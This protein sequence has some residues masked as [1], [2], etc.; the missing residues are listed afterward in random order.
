MFS[1]HTLGIIT[2]LPQ[3]ARTLTSGRLSCKQIMRLKDRIYLFIGGMG[4]ENS[5]QAATTL[6]KHGAT[7]LISW[8]TAGALNPI[9]QAGDLIIPTQ[10]KTNKPNTLFTVDI[11]HQAQLIT[12]LP[13]SL[14]ISQQAVL[15]SNSMVA[16]V[17]D[18]Q[19]LYQQHQAAAIDMESYAIATAAHNANLAFL[20]IRAI[21][22]PA[23]MCL[24]H[25]ATRAYDLSGKLRPFSLINQ[26]I[27][28]PREWPL[29]AHLAKNLKKAQATLIQ[30]RQALLTHIN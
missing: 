22:D 29:L 21:I 10:I 23:D 28:Y 8:G 2:A 26:L 30:V 17:T 27:Q 16:A 1:N 20:A 6:I 11:T 15:H 3:E 13:S 14:S 18:K 12:Q 7:F 4:S 25:A 5:H 19:Q 9:L 24:P